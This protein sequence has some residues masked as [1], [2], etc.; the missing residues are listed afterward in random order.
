MVAK[1]ESQSHWESNN[2]NNGDDEEEYSIANEKISLELILSDWNK[3]QEQVSRVIEY[4]RQAGIRNPEAYIGYGFAPGTTEPADV[5]RRIR[6]WNSI[7]NKRT[8]KPNTLEALRNAGV[9]SDDEMD[10]FG[11]N[12]VFPKRELS[13]I[14]R[15]HKNDGSEWLLRQERFSGL[16][17]IGGVV[18]IPV[19]LGYYR[20]VTL[21]PTTAALENGNQVKVLQIGTT[22]GAY[23]TLPRI[24]YIKFTKENVL[25]ALKVAQPIMEN[26]VPVKVSYTLQFEGQTRAIGVPTLEEITDG[27]FMEIWERSSKPNPQINISSKD[28]AT[29]VKLDRESRE[30]ANQYG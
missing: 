1:K 19:T 26:G 21:E 13:Q 9:I 7:I 22:E 25:D 30:K 8:G 5:K 28:L 4:N 15:I 23:Y 2:N 16:N 10:L 18:S 17:S 12:P 24:Y 20:R 29:Y 3:E 6:W 14:H 27:D 11:D